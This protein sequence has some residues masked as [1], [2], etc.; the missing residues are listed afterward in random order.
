M[1]LFF[2]LIGA[3][4]L[5]SVMSGYVVARTLGHIDLRKEGSGNVGARNAGRLLG[6]KAFVLTFL[7]DALKGFFVVFIPAVFFDINPAIL[8]F[9]LAAAV[10]GHLKPITLR[11]KGGKGV[12][13][14][15]GGIAAFDYKVL[16]VMIVLFLVLYL[17]LRSFTLAGLAAILLVPIIFYLLSYSWLHCFLMLSIT[18]LVIFAHK[19]NVCDRLKKG[20]GCG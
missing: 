1:Y 20:G 7:G 12:S 5:G 16:L 18:L 2:Y 10:I 11:F 15:I 17:L 6:K 8:L 13:T 4:L 14:F 3:Y 19:E 9:G